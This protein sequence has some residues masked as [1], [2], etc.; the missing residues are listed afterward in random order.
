MAGEENTDMLGNSASSSGGV[1]ADDKESV[2]GDEFTKLSS[3]G[4]SANSASDIT[5]VGKSELPGDELA[6]ATVALVS[7]EVERAIGVMINSDPQKSVSIRKLVRASGLTFSDFI[8]TIS[9][10]VARIIFPAPESSETAI[11]SILSTVRKGC[12]TALETVLQ[13]ESERLS[14]RSSVAGVTSNRVMASRTGAKRP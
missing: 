14:T 8:T 12:R 9:G 7:A 11:G 4:D 2:L 13:T 10:K 6:E 5:L 3:V 1:D